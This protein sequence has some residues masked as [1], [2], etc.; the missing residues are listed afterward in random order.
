M[1]WAWQKVFVNQRTCV[2]FQSPPQDW[3]VVR[4]FPDMPKKGVLS[5]RFG[6]DAKTLFVGAADHNLRVFGLSA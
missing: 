3:S 5:L 2:F 4:S 6:G 1:T